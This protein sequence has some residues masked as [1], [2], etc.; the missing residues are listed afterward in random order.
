M[1][2]AWRASASVAR[3]GKMRAAGYARRHKLPCFGICYGMQLAVIELARNL[4]GIPGAGTTEFGKPDYPA[5]GL[6]GEWTRGNTSEVRT[7]D[8]DL[9]GTMRLGAY[10]AVLTKGSKVA[11]IYGTQTI[12]ERHR[13]RYEVNTD[14][15]A[16]LAPHGV[17]L[18]RHVP[19]WQACRRSWSS[20][21]I[22]GS[23]ASSSTPS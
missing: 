9:G 6:M 15:I 13:H 21:T 11:A 4:A 18:L 1:L 19:G 22:R 14:I 10:P 8:G 3:I 23:S 2:S 17:L 5:V 7:A 16:R 12:S 20:P